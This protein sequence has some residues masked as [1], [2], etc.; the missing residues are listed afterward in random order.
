MTLLYDAL[1]LAGAVLIF[2]VV[3]YAVLFVM[4]VL[5]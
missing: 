4:L 3:S 1:R 5:S 2:T